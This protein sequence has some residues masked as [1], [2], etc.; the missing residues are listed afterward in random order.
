MCEISR[1]VKPCSIT[2]GGDGSWKLI[3]YNGYETQN[4][5]QA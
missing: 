4:S 2:S 1:K 5:S 3:D